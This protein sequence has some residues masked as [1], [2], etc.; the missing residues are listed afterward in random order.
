MI[1]V[2]ICFPPIIRKTQKQRRCWH[3]AKLNMY[4]FLFRSNSKAFLICYQSLA[5]YSPLQC[6][7]PWTK[8]GDFVFRLRIVE[9]ILI[10]RKI[11]VY[12][13]ESCM[14]NWTIENSKLLKLAKDFLMCYDEILHR[15]IQ[16]IE[17]KIMNLFFH[18]KQLDV[19]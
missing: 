15:N 7:R 18:Y 16:G 2:Q 11:F 10:W 1:I 14:Q 5:R 13:L 4:Y 6:T 12:G 3:S 8:T 9:S 17:Y 19:Y